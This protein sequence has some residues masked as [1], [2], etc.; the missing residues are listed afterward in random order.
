MQVL[1]L[2]FKLD[3]FI[4]ELYVFSTK[5]GWN[6]DPI[7]NTMWKYLLSF[8]SLPFHSVVVSFVV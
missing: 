2:F 6:I 4:F 5:F 3:P 8:S 7:G 1:W